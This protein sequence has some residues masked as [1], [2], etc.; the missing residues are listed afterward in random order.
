MD[1][2]RIYVTGAGAVSAC[3]KDLEENILEMSSAASGLRP[4]ALSDGRTVLPAGVFRLNDREL[5]ELLGIDSGEPLSR[6]SLLGL[7]A[8]RE[9]VRDHMQ[10]TGG[11]LPGR[12]AFISG[13]SAGGMDL[14]EKFWEEHR[15]DPWSGDPACLKVHDPG[16]S[17]LSIMQ[18]APENA[19]SAAFWDKVQFCTTTS[20]ACSSA[21]NAIM[22]AARMIRAGVIDMAVAGGADALCGFTLNGFNSLRIL[23]SEN[24]RPFDVSRAGLNLGEGA[25][26]LVLTSG[27]LAAGRKNDAL[28]ILSGWGN[29]DDAYHQT[30]SSPEGT[31]P[32]SAMRGALATAGLAP[33]DIGFINTHGTGTQINDMAESKA[34]KDVFRGNVPP[35]S[36]VK[37]FFGH[38]LGAS[39]GIEAALVCKA[40][41][42]NDFRFM[43]SLGFSTAEED[44]GLVPY[45]G[46]EDLHPSHVMSSAFGFGGNCVSLVFSRI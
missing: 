19:D 10:R 34:M 43:K 37:P 4:L 24:C 25:G 42:D 13:T 33:E 3:G 5:R 41:S 32:A 30:A 29:A 16:A 39:E 15:H 8:V 40:L 9:A 44:S 22:T 28:C 36:S 11:L 12:A 6:T 31:G 2:G 20:T 7:V 35:F 46:R 23:D 18:F 14:S 21:G 26:Y 27:R 1:C 45:D 17:T 38:A